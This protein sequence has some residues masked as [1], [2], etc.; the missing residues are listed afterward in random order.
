MTDTDKNRRVAE[1]MGWEYNKG[2]RGK[3]GL[4]PMVSPYWHRNDE[5]RRHY[6]DYLADITLVGEMLEWLT[7]NTRYWCLDSIYKFSFGLG[8]TVDHHQ[9][10]VETIN[11]ALVDAIIT[12]G[13]V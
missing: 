4:G 5:R 10:E 12:V 1:V 7:K 2:L 13:E 6:P 3:D 9:Y 11:A 8:D